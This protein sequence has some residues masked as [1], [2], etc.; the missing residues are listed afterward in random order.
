MRAVVTHLAGVALLGLAMFLAPPPTMAQ[1][2]GAGNIQGTI[3]DSTGAVIPNASVSL[4]ERATH[5]TLSTKSDA[6]GVYAFPNV[7]VGTYSLI[8]RAPGFQ[9]YTSSGNVLEVGSSI[10]I[11][12]KLTVG[13]QDVNVEVH[14]E[15][16]ALQTEDPSFKQTVDE[17]EVTEMPLNGRLLTN[18]VQFAGAEFANSPGDATGSK[19]TWQSTGISIA[20]APGNSVTWT[21]DGGIHVDFMG[22]TN[23]P[24]PFPD[25]VSQFSVE[26]SVL[27]S[28]NGFHSGAGV[29]IVTRSGTNLYHGSGFEFLRNNFIDATNFF[30]TS[31]DTLHQNQYGGT[32]GGP[33]RIPRLFNGKNKLFFFFAYQFEKS[34]SAASNSFAYVPTAANLAGDFSNTDPPPGAAANNC[35]KP[36]QLFDPIT[37][38]LLPGNKYPSPP[39]W[40][41]QALALEK[42][43]PAINAA[44]D[45]YNC[46][47]VSYAI[48]S[49][50]FDKELDTRVDYTIN[51]ADNLYVAYYLDGY[52]APAFYSPTDILLTANSGNIE[53]TQSLTIGENHIFSTHLVNSAHLTGIRRTNLR[54]YNS[55]DINATTL[56]VNDFQYQPIGLQLSAGTSGKN[57]GFTVGGGSNS[58]AVIND[59][60]PV[61]IGDDLTWVKGRHQF[62]FGGGYIRNQLNLNN[63]YNGN[64]VFSFNGIYSGNGP[65]GAG[66]GVGASSNASPGDANLDFLDGSMNSFNQSRPQQNALRG[67]I[68]TL[69]AQDT[70]HA[71]KQL[72]VVA[73]IRWQPYFVPP[74]VFHRGMVFNYAAFLANQVSTVYTKA[75]AGALYYGDP[76]VPP[77][78]TKGTPLHFNPN[79]GATYDVFGT[80]KTVIRAGAELAYDSPNF[81]ITQRVQQSPPFATN[82]SPNTSAQLCLSEPWL[83]GGTGYGCGQ[84]GGINS[85][86]F[87]MPPVPT[88]AAAIFPAQSQYI[89]AQS[90]WEPP[91]TLQWTFSIQQ[92]LPRGWMIQIDYVG[93]RTQ[94]MVQGLPLSP[95]VFIPGVWGPGGTGC[96]GIVTTGPAAVKPGAAGTNCSTTGNENSRFALTIANPAQGNQYS[97]GGGGS[98]VESNSAYSNYNGM[99]ATVQHRLSATFSLNSNFTWSKCMND[100]DPQGDISGTQVENPASPKMDYGLCGSSSKNIFNTSLIAKSAFPLHG[101]IGYIANNW[102]LAPLLHITSGQ[103]FTVTTGSDVS[104]TD[105]G[106]DRP[107]QIPGTNPYHYVKIYAGSATLATRSYLN[108]AAFCTNG[109]ASCAAYAPALGT[110]GNIGRNSFYGPMYL[111]ADAQL[112]RL[113]PIREKLT[114]DTRI[115]AFNVLNH[116]SFSNPNSSNPASGSFGEITGTSNGARV[117]QLGGKLSF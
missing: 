34:D 37:G 7:A 71:N 103:P 42:Y 97:G 43:L 52:Q 54:G 98:L 68:T 110:Y 5:V 109:E 77:G 100:V 10:A 66:A 58:K 12:A 56:G 17:R 83:I 102:E 106:N 46:G 104:L 13:K 32:F 91:N 36:Q 82:T 14:S 60:T 114:L 53:Q 93:S 47:E 69:Y 8:V 75:P 30:S 57:H 89:V 85:S 72:T 96:A 64:G 3:T 101:V 38:L 78:F 21:L 45:V 22:G 63:T 76:G 112:S 9:T 15:G 67:P 31:K 33:V 111:D 16:L 51:P 73:G 24:L 107:N 65:T 95:A 80:G 29:N 99:I 55:A 79:F 1:V 23:L 92:Q 84:V 88:P 62:V 49:E 74:D 48:P 61:A 18:L 26:T 108:Q 94:H 44:V 6:S 115:E 70:F 87:P 59:N 41:A 105:I 113:F 40:N 81:F 25:A 50:F 4:I 39:T 20:G 2:S 117:F 19:F 116:P 28:E 11:N 86:P 27:G 35:G 90:Q